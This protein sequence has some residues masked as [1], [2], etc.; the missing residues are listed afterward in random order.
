MTIKEFA[1]LCGCNPQTLRYYDRVDLLKPVKVDQRSG[2]RYYDEEQAIRYVKIKNLQLSGF[3]IDEIK[4]LLDADS[5]TV[6][7]AF[8]R[9]IRQQEEKL[10][11]IKEIQLSYQDEIQKMKEKVQVLKDAIL[12]SMTQYDLK[13]EFG[14][15]DEEYKT[16]FDSFIAY[17]ENHEFSKGDI[18][19][20]LS[21]E[22]DDPADE[23]KY[24]DFLNDP[25]YE[26]VYELHDWGRIKEIGEEFIMPEDGSDYLLLF[27][28]TEDRQNKTA[29]A[30][31]ALSMLSG[32]NLKENE[33]RTPH[34]YGCSVDL[35]DDG[36]NHFWLLKA[37]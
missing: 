35:S 11:K 15:D 23:R 25:N 12:S 17:L 36:S 32:V 6:N 4:D 16:I 31:T 27:A 22:E 7:D 20:D 5:V 28:L 29:F 13:D 14:I 2:Y 3:S 18:E 26:I 21:S 19:H 8:T 37:R 33:N 34:K 1:R 10:I 9:K 24:L 30:I